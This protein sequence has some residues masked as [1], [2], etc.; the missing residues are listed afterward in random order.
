MNMTM[1]TRQ[2]LTGLSCV[3]AA[4]IVHY[5]WQPL[6]AQATPSPTAKPSPKAHWEPY[7]ARNAKPS[8][9]QELSDP[10][11]TGAIDLHAHHGPDAYDRQWDAFEVVKLAKERGMRAVVLKNHWTETAGLAQLIR[12]Y[13]APGIEVFGSVTLDTPVG[14]VNPMAVRYM[15]DVEGTRGRIVWMPTHDSEHEVNYYKETRAKAIVSRNG[16]LIPEVFEVLDL[17]KERNL[18]L[19]TG[20]VTPEETLMIMAAARQRGITRIIVTHPLLG[21]QF[22]ELTLPQMQEAVTLGGA[23]E[24]TAGALRSD[25]AAK[26]RAIEVIKAL[27]T[28]NVF[29]GSDSGL[30][31][32]PNHPDALAMA[33]KSLRAAGFSEQDLNRMF[34]E[35]P[36]RL[37]G[38]PVQ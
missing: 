38:L 24:I 9:D 11:L 36:A 2:L 23:I 32:T 10:V 29:V 34:K 12:K 30:I 5:G 26:T 28:Q 21:P 3:A 31:G 18:T 16:R 4:V 1:R 25:G 20:H 35:T 17:I 14:G 7:K 22:T 15:A 37:V 13:G 6:L 8:V 19:A 27:G 33:I